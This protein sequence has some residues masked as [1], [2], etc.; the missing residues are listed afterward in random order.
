M[1]GPAFH[2]NVALEGPLG[3]LVVAFPSVTRVEL[4]APRWQHVGTL[5]RAGLLL[6]HD[7]CLAGRRLVL[8]GRGSRRLSCARVTP[9]SFVAPVGITRVVL[10][11]AG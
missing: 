4:C 6:G 3:G 8:L 10:R 1:D 11:H 5:A 7:A 9:S 2:A